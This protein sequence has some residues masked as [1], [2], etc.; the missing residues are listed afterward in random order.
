MPEPGSSPAPLDAAIGLT[1]EQVL[2]D[3]S[4]ELLLEPQPVAVGSEE[5]LYLHG[6]ALATC[7]DTAGW[8]AVTARRPGAWIALNLSCEFLRL[9]DRRPMAVHATCRKVGATTAVVDVTIFRR[10][11]RD[12]PVAIG[13][14][15][16]FRAGDG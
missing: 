11:E 16:F 3:G 1:F 10:E 14:A 4:V 15:T 6:G 7:V 12:R 2:L 8:Y 13:R 9:A 5:P